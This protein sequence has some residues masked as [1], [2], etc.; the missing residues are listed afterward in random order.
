MCWVPYNQLQSASVF[1]KY[2][3][4]AL[5]ALSEM[6]TAGTASA[7]PALRCC[8]HWLACLPCQ[9]MLGGF[10]T[11]HARRCT[12]PAAC[13]QPSKHMQGSDTS[14]HCIH[15]ACGAH[16]TYVYCAMLAVCYMHVQTDNLLAAAPGLTVS[17]QISSSLA[18][19]CANSAVTQI[20]YTN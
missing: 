15:Q 12:Q 4:S 3:W 17:H 8:T 5:K 11:T 19:V 10:S 7:Q 13:G 16:V 2:S 14:G 6:V 1:E 9:H 20:S 18:V